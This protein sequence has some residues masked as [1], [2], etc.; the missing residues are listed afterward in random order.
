MSRK[1]FLEYLGMSELDDKR[2][3]NRLFQC[4]K[5]TFS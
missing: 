4:A 5:S 3:G 2:L 1:K